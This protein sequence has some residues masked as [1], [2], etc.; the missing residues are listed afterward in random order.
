MRD[1]RLGY[2]R[3]KTPRWWNMWREWIELCSKV[4][5][6]LLRA[7]RVVMSPVLE[8]DEETI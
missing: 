6:L 3:A 2:E 1:G 8:A 7:V 4:K 5:R